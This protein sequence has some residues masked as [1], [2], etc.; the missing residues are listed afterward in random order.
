[1]WQMSI[2]RAGETAWTGMPRAGLDARDDGPAPGPPR[3]SLYS[4]YTSLFATSVAGTPAETAAAYRIRYQVYCLDHAFEDPAEHPDGL[5]RDA[6]DARSVHALL[7]YA[8]T[9]AVAGTV[10]LILPDRRAAALPMVQ[11]AGLVG[12]GTLLPFPAEATAEVSRFAVTRAVR[13]TIH[14]PGLPSGIRQLVLSH[15]P[16]GLI[17]GLVA[18]SARHGV[19]HWCALMEPAL[20]RLLGRLGIHFQPIGPL[21]DHHGRRQ[22]C[23]LEVVPMLRRVQADRRDV[24]EVIT[25]RG[26]CL[27]ANP[28]RCRSWTG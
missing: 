9:G 21:V 2:A 13:D 24:W 27:P 22:P 15:L 10:R 26:N 17:R 1:M 8:P 5:E 11:S 20:L 19:T 3:P 7:R 6:F 14:G 23:W 12:E 25:D 4:A 18:M 16:L 28:E